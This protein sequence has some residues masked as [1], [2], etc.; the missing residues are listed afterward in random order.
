MWKLR[1]KIEP[2]PREMRK[3]FVETLGEMME[4]DK[5]IMA[6]DA[7]LGGASGFC[8]LK[9]SHPEQFVD[10]GIAEANMMGIAAGMSMRG[11]I[12]YVHTFSPFASRRVADQVFLA[13]AYSGNT[14]HIYGSDPG[15][16]A[17]A[18]GGTHTTFEDI[19]IYRAMPQTMIF[20]PADAVQLQWL[21]R[22]IKPLAGV[23]YIRANR[24]TVADIYA[25]GSS[26]QIG[27]GN[28]V[29]EGKDVVLISMGELLSDAIA[30]A[31]D[32]EED[33]ISVEVIDMFSIKPFDTE[34]IQKEI[35]GKS[36]VVTFEN[37]SVYNGLGS[38]VAEAMAEKGAG[39]P[40]RRIGIRDRFGQV[41]DFEYLKEA[42]GLTAKRVK[43]VIK[44]K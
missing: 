9:K 18:N 25:P 21:I 37:H 1:E 38:A 32:L 11:F 7:D 8:S 22:E 14:I 10:V 39:I 26:F 19:A 35:V 23:H 34:L 30:A 12:P 43:D 2:G 42:Y 6:L 28:V 27:K 44:G 41:G 31:M 17:A 4:E 13:G 5:K 29:K 40:L 15:I 16:C 33:G 24:K 36:M 3:V 20:A